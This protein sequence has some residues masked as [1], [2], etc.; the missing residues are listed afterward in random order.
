[1]LLKSFQYIGV[2]KDAVREVMFA[3]PSTLAKLPNL[4]T[5]W[6]NVIAA[7]VSQRFPKLTSALSDSLINELTPI[8]RE[9]YYS[10]MQYRLTID[11]YDSQTD[12][13]TFREEYQVTIN[14]HPTEQISY[15][16]VLF[17]EW[18]ESLEVAPYEI[19]LLRVNSSDCLNKVALEGNRG[20]S[21]IRLGYEIPLSGSETFVVVRTMRRSQCLASDPFLQ[22]SS[23]RFSVGLEMTIENRVSDQVDWKHLPIGVGEEDMKDEPLGPNVRRLRLERLIFPRQGITLVFVRHPN[24]RAAVPGA[25]AGSA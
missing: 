16:F 22:I 10:G 12:Y 18:P 24:M 1:M 3:E 7:A 5:I 13:V 19:T 25:A 4:N 14:A 20:A 21:T 6:R 9:Y 8:A 2:F 23:T 11:G 15:K 17:G